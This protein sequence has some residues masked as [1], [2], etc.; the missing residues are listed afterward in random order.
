M[1]LNAPE[2]PTALFCWHDRLGYETLE[3][4]DRLG[5]AVPDRLSLVGYDG[6][7]WPST[8]AHLLTSIH[9]PLQEAAT[10]AVRLLDDLV[11]GRRTDAPEEWYPVTFSE[12]STL[13]PPAI[14][15]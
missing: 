2:P 9:I 8:S 11:E 4:C 6:L 13:A 12:G 10:R 3:A 7:H 14:L 1:L 15:H 5:I